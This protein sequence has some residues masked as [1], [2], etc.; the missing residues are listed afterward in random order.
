MNSEAVKNIFQGGRK[1]APKLSKTIFVVEAAGSGW[2]PA[3]LTITNG[4]RGGKR[5]P[6]FYGPYR[7][8]RVYAGIHEN[9]RH[10]TWQK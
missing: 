1:V 5:C 7:K 9:F 10:D 4:N 8:K 2:L 3:V 6:V